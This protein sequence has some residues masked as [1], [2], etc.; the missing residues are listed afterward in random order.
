MRLAYTP[1]MTWCDEK[2]AVQTISA[3]N[4][5]QMKLAF[6]NFDKIKGG[7]SRFT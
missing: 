6:D 1:D 2:G 4:T 5:T 3:D 7:E